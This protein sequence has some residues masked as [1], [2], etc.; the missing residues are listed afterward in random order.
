MDTSDAQ[1]SLGS[2]GIIESHPTSALIIESASV[3]EKS[4]KAQSPIQSKISVNVLFFF[5][6][7][8]DF[9]TNNLDITKFKNFICIKSTNNK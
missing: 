6:L 5:L 9:Y 2:D 4:T 1:A 7:C 8:R 3:S